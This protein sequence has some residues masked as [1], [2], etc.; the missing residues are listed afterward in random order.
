[1]SAYIGVAAC[2]TLP[3]AL[4]VLVW[5]GAGW[6]TRGRPRGFVRVGLAIIAGVVTLE[7]LCVLPMA[8][9]EQAL[10]SGAEEVLL[11]FVLVG[12]LGR[13]VGLWLLMLGFAVFALGFAVQSEPLPP[14]PR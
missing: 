13:L 4:A 8:A 11:G 6:N 10:R 14:P 1:M 7:G 5:M 12:L 9:V 2:W 3:W